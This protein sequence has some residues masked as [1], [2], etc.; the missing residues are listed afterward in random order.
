[1]QL[2]AVAHGE[3]VYEDSVI[4]VDSEE[5]SNSDHNS[6]EFDLQQIGSY[7]FLLESNVEHSN[8]EEQI[9]QTNDTTEN[10]LEPNKE[11]RTS[12]F[13]NEILAEKVEDIEDQFLKEHFNMT[14]YIC[15]TSVPNFTHLNSHFQNMHQEREAL[16][17]CCG[18]KFSDR[19]LIVKHLRQKNHLGCLHCKK[20]FKLKSS[21]TN[22]IIKMH[23][24][25]EQKSNS[26]IKCNKNFA[27]KPDMKL[28][29]YE[30]HIH[31]N[32]RL[33]CQI[34]GWWVQRRFFK[35]HMKAA[36]CAGEIEPVKFK[37]DKC[38][39]SFEHKALLNIHMKRH[40]NACSMCKTY[41]S[42]Q[43]FL[44]RHM[45]TVHRM[46]AVCAYCSKYFQ[47]KTTYELHVNVHKGIEAPQ[48]LS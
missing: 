14:C 12:K 36:H 35:R 31:N 5:T 48:V 37:C 8:A 40:Q 39:Q 11:T 28:H 32:E 20:P 4:E 19:N 24:Q 43:F 3:S 34:C 25:S 21:L 38:P 30:E 16:V 26:C 46:G 44:N 13:I 10:M 9:M 33:P 45:A 42:N 22:H 15:G 27:S 1:M 23:N 18:G 6:Q 17:V 7:G 41:F 2:N 29:F 47:C